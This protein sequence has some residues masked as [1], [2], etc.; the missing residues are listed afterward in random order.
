MTVSFHQYGN[1]FFPN[2]GYHSSKGCKDGLN[3][4]LNI[5]LKQ[6]I[7]DDNFQELFKPIMKRV[8]DIYQPNV[9]VL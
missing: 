3:Y 4:S 7:K 8:M 9:V 6:W 5:P 1:G 2:S